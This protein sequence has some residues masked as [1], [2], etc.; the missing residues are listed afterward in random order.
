M[1]SKFDLCLLPYVIR[2]VGWLKHCDLSLSHTKRLTQPQHV[3]SGLFMTYQR[4][5][6]KLGALSNQAAS[7]DGVA[8]DSMLYRQHDFI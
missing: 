5:G 3:S 8:T 4:S 2:L 6:A 7:A 1:S